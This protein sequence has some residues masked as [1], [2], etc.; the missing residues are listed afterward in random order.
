MD[1]SGQGTQSGPEASTSQLESLSLQGTQPNPSGSPP[2][3]F[4]VQEEEDF[5]EFSSFNSSKANELKPSSSNLDH[6]KGDITPKAPYRDWSSKEQYDSDEESLDDPTQGAARPGARDA[7][8]STL[9]HN[10][11]AEGDADLL[12]SGGPK[13]DPLLASDPSVDDSAKPT[14]VFAIPFPEA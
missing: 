10:S 12:I 7:T 1:H 2:K 11:T 3:Q 4:Q 6:E 14:V 9:T 8:G 5:G 13:R